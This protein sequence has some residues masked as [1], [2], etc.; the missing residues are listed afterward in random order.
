MA[1]NHIH[2]I[3]IKQVAIPRSQSNV[4]FSPSAAT[5]IAIDGNLA[6]ILNGKAARPNKLGWESAEP[7]RRAFVCQRKL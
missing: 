4:V 5:I 6:K 3:L 2:T 7:H 1:C